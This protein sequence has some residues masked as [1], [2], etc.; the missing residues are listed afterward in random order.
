MFNQ[1][2]PKVDNR[3]AR[4]KVAAFHAEDAR[5]QQ[6]RAQLEAEAQQ[7]ALQEQARQQ[8]QAERQQLE[9][10]RRQR[11]E[12]EELESMT[13]EAS[14]YFEQRTNPQK[15][16][17]DLYSKARRQE[18]ESFKARVQREYEQEL[19]GQRG[20][21]VGQRGAR[22]AVAQQHMQEKLQAF[23]SEREARELKAEAQPDELNRLAHSLGAEGQKVMLEL[24]EKQPNKIDLVREAKQ[25][26]AQQTQA[27]RNHE[28]YT[29][30][31][32]EMKAKNVRGSTWAANT[33]AKY[34]AMGMDPN[35]SEG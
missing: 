9:A 2:Q 13:P 8:A 21:A 24:I 20:G 31:V 33:R 35:Y 14:A 34:V 28:L 22:R 4:E 30:F 19:M 10:L 18:E 23:Y 12:A 3:S 7:E 27:A 25:V 32:Q 16:V 15:L 1:N 5:K 6:E 17:A 29:A 11:Q 26:T